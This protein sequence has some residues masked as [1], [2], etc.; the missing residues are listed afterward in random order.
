MQKHVFWLELTVQ[1]ED[2]NWL[3]FCHEQVKVMN[4]LSMCKQGPP[5]THADIHIKHL[6]CTIC[7]EHMCLCL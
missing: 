7:V 5:W 3:W 2:W 4:L 6:R 1:L